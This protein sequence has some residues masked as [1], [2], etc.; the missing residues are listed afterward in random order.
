M[1]TDVWKNV[2]WCA[3]LYK[4]QKIFHDSLDS[5]YHA[6]TAN[7]PLEGNVTLKKDGSGNWWLGDALHKQ[8]FHVVIYSFYMGTDLWRES[9]GNPFVVQKRLRWSG[10]TSCSPWRPEVRGSYCRTV[11][12]EWL[13]C[14]CP[15]RRP[16]G[17]RKHI[18]DAARSQ[19][20]WRPRGEARLGEF[21]D[22][23]YL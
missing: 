19:T 15:H 17:G 7:E 18:P 9:L 5:F 13:P 14:R 10:G 16:P 23:L 11:G 6:L 1:N 4:S 8:P 3:H 22:K 12:S 20:H 2:R 21:S